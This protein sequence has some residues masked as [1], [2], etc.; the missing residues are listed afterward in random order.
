MNIVTSLTRF[1]KNKNTVTI[2]GVIA[3]IAILY[4]GYTQQIKS[5]TNPVRVPIAKQTIQPGT[6]ITTDMI[7]YVSIPKIG[8]SDNVIRAVNSIVGKYTNYNTCNTF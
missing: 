2:L 6:L 8:V 7:D 5:Q 4:F 1:F 3:V